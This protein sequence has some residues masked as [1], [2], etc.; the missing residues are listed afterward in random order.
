[1][2]CFEIPS[3]DFSEKMRVIVD[4]VDSRQLSRLWLFYRDF[5]CG[6]CECLDYIFNCVR[7]EPVL[8]SQDYVIGM[9][10]LNSADSEY[11]RK[12]D[13]NIFIP[14]RM[15]NSIEALV[16]AA[17]DI[18]KVRHQHDIFML[19]F[20][21]TCIETLVQLSGIRCSKREMLFS[22]FEDNI[23]DKD[24]QFILDRIRFAGVGEELFEEYDS[25]DAFQAFIGAIYEYRNSALHNGE[26]SETCFNN[27]DDRD[28]WPTI[29]VITA[30]PERL[31]RNGKNGR[32]A[33]KDLSFSSQLSYVEFENIF[34]RTCIA[35]IGKYVKKLS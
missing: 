12:V 7:H 27:R 31:K 33:K 28:K 15:L 29:C 16:S 24:K 6:D 20:L 13:E 14:R 32:R 3:P 10:F 35:F 18:R 34:V 19:I 17:R 30:D 2:D 9:G 11:R 5:F 8:D 25:I 21:I 1:M 4:R 26:F 23:S 22:F